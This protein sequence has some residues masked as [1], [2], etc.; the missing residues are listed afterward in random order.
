MCLVTYLAFITSQRLAQ[1]LGQNGINVISKLM[2]LILTV[3]GVQMIIDGV[4]ALMKTG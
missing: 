4:L 3:V 1:L 2:G